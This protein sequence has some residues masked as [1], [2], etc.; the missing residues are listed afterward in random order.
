MPNAGQAPSALSPFN[1]QFHARSSLFSLGAG[2]PSFT[3]RILSIPYFRSRVAWS[4]LKCA[5]PNFTFEGGLDGLP[6]RAAFS[7]AHPLACR[8]V[9]L[10]QARAFRFFTFPRGSR[11]IILH[12]AH[13]AT[14]ALSWGLCEQGGWLPAPH[15]PTCSSAAQPVDLWRC[16]PAWPE[17]S[18]PIV[19]Q[20][21]DNLFIRSVELCHLQSS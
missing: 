12:C 15:L 14:T 19:H 6:L 2:K 10:A 9:P 3:A 16:D 20:L 7:P 11:Q 4:I 21:I 18:C 5:N 17:Q 13:R 8:D 1:S